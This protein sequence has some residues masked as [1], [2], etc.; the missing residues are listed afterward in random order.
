MDEVGGDSAH[1][2]FCCLS[3]VA[4]YWSLRVLKSDENFLPSPPGFAFVFHRTPFPL[5]SLSVDD[6]PDFS[7][8]PFSDT[9]VTSGIGGLQPQAH[10]DG[11]I[12]RE[13]RLFAELH[14]VVWPAWRQRTSGQLTPVGFA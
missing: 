6:D 8:R 12:L 10:F 1:L 4:R 3:Q 13:A 2:S 7:P 11:R 9:K 5:A 14:P